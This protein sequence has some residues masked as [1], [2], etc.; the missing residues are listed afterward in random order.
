ME[1]YL[2]VVSGIP[3]YALHSCKGS[4]K[5]IMLKNMVARILQLFYKQFMF[6]QQVIAPFKRERLTATFRADNH[7]A[8]ISSPRCRG[9]V[10]GE[11]MEEN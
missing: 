7:S 2:S 3:S 9:G 6:R 10:G 4:K 11:F 8:N 5:T 1:F